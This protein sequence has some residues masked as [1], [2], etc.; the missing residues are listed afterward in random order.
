VADA[1]AALTALATVPGHPLIVL[2]ATGTGGRVLWR[3][4]CDQRH[5]AR[6]TAALRAHLTELRTEPEPSTFDGLVD[7]AAGVRVRGDRALPL[8]VDA[9]EPAVRGLLAVLAGTHRNESVHIQLV[10]GTRHRPSQRATNGAETRDR[11]RVAVKESEHRFG[12]EVRLAASSDDPARARS[13][14]ESAAA[15][16]RVLEVPGLRIRL[17]RGSAKAFTAASSPFLWPN[18][19]SVSDLVPLSAWPVGELPL[20]GVASAHPKLLPP[21]HHLPR[22]GRVLGD[23]V[24]SGSPRPVALSTDDALRH[25]HVIGPTGVGKS[26][27]LANLALQDMAAENGVV[28][29]DPKGDLVEDLLARIPVDRRDDVVVLDAHDACPVGINPLVGNTSPDL[30]ADVTLGVLHSLYADSWGPRTHDILHACL[31]TLARRGDASLV[32]VPLLLTNIGFRRSITGRL[33]RADPIGLGSFWAW[34]E[35]ISDG[36]RQA[37]IAPLM[38]KL[39]PVLLRPGIRAVLGQR[40]PKFDISDVFTKRQVL[41]VSLAKG[42]IG[43]EAAQLLGSLVVALLWQ[44]AL[45]RMGTAATRRRPVSV[46]VDEV[47]DYLQ[48]P[49]DLGDALAQARG[50]GVGFTLAHQ[51]LGQLP[52]GLREAILANARSRVAFQLSTADAKVIAATTRRALVPEDFEALPAFGAYASVLVD[53]ASA[54]WVSLGTR[55][56][57]PVSA[58]PVTIRGLSAA[59]YGRALDE[60]EAD[61]LNLVDATA[62]AI[63]TPNGDLGRSLRADAG[64][65]P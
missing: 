8:K 57:P 56:L 44:S 52:K 12:C 22:T 60:V 38:N 4:G 6:I 19:L 40:F 54:P 63:T 25:L 34:Y 20:P 18:H 31:L 50:L 42:Q 27:L 37:A 64:G 32:M 49:G 15:A 36:E 17:N 14:I 59:R 2:E 30:A 48:L 43:P 58:D 9:T 5:D 16:L 41:L 62:E 33:V 29:I 61:L 53:G 11:R 45:A 26:T 10:L 65:A 13:L 39:R 47:Q 24:V 7:V 28:V 23:A 51:H 1:R 21:S 3:L 55:P 46:I 35:G